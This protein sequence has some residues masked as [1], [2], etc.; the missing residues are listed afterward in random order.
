MLSSAIAG[1]QPLR[2]ADFRNA[3]ALSCS[4]STIRAATIFRSRL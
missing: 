2:L 1:F 4:A 3:S